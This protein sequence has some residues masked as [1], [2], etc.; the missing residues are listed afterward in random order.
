MT[1][2]CALFT[3]L[4]TVLIF[5]SEWSYHNKRVVF[6]IA[7]Y[8]WARKTYRFFMYLLLLLTALYVLVG[9]IRIIK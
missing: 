6:R 7:Q 1:I 8:P 5:W 4:V 3:L 9:L 2:D